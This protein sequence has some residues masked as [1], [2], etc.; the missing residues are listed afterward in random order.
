MTAHDEI[1]CPTCWLAREISF[2]LDDRCFEPEGLETLTAWLG[3]HAGAVERAMAE[4][5]DA[6]DLAPDALAA[7]ADAAELIASW[8]RTGGPTG[9]ELEAE[10]RR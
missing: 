8:R 4:G 10:V 2:A 5:F 7:A 1:E 9:D 3:D 6:H